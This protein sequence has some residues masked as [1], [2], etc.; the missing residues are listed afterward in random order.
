[1]AH[2]ALQKL[3]ILPGEFE[4]LPRE[5]KAFIYAS[6]EL[7]IQSEKAAWKK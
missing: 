1:M 2:F 7:R 4:E 3:R 5:E 6:I